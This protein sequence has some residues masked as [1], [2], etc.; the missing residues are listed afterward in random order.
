MEVLLI[1]PLIILCLVLFIQIGQALYDALQ[2]QS[3]PEDPAGQTMPSQPATWIRKT[4]LLLDW[5]RG[6]TSLLP[7]WF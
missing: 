4:D 6:L 1:M 5:G 7:G 3:L 2:R